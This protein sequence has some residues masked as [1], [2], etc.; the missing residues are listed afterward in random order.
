MPIFYIKTINCGCIVRTMVCGVKNTPNGKMYSLGCHEF[1]SVCND[2]SKFEENEDL[3]Y[4]MW[5]NDKF[6]NDIG[7]GEW[8]KWGKYGK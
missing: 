6:T 5:M 3:L 4:D 8:K 1:L 7:Y 2:C